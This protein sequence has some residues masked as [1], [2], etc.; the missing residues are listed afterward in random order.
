MMKKTGFLLQM[1]LIVTC[2]IVGVDATAQ[3][4]DR[5]TFEKHLAKAR[6]LTPQR[7]AATASPITLTQNP[8]EIEEFS[9]PSGSS[10]KQVNIYFNTAVMTAYRSEC[11]PRVTQFDLELPAGFSISALGVSSTLQNSG[12]SVVGN[13]EGNTL[14]FLGY[15]SLTADQLATLPTGRIHYATLTLKKNNE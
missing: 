5:T 11:C 12:I 13:V 2:L 10:T 3:L 14:H 4:V 1:L 8:F 7:K 15:G 6:S 9:I